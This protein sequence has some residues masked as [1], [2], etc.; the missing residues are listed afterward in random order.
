MESTTKGILKMTTYT[1]TITNLSCLDPDIDGDCGT[2][3]SASWD[4]SAIGAN[5]TVMMNGVTPLDIS[6]QDGENPEGL[7]PALTQASVITYVQDAMG[8]NQVN[9]Y[10]KTLDDRLVLMDVPAPVV[11]SPVLPWTV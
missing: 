1:W 9:A 7:F 2:L 4:L 11:I 8:I 10:K 5:N 3:L 6:M